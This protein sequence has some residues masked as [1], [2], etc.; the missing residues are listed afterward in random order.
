MIFHIAQQI[1][2][3]TAEK[4][5]T[6]DIPGL[7][8]EGFIHCSTA[9]QVVRTANRLFLGRRDLVLLEIDETLVVPKVIFEGRLEKFPHIYGPIN[10]NAVTKVHPF[11]PLANGEFLLPQP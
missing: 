3:Q 6:Y 7:H 1:D 5:G 2:W 8:E 4:A 9:E 10:L 11:Q